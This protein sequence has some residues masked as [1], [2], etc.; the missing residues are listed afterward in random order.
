MFLLR[1]Q[2]F[3]YVPLRVVFK[4]GSFFVCYVMVRFFVRYVCISFAI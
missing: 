1:R 3:I 2:L 4:F